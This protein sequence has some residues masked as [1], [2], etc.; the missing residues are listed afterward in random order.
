MQTKTDRLA[1]Q[2]SS[3]GSPT[4]AR[5]FSYLFLSQPFPLFLALLFVT[6][7]MLFASKLKRFFIDP[8]AG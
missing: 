5:R 7:L 6:N 1:C 8:A 2:R 4:L 3:S